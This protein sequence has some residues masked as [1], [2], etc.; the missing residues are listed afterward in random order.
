M[1]VPS[2]CC[3]VHLKF[4]TPSRCVKKCCPYLRRCDKFN[5]PSTLSHCDR[6]YVE[7]L[8]NTHCMHILSGVCKSTNS[9][10]RS[11]YEVRRA[12]K[13]PIIIRRS[14]FWIDQLLLASPNIYWIISIKVAH[15]EE[16]ATPGMDLSHESRFG[17]AWRW[18]RY[19]DQPTPT[20]KSPMTWGVLAN[21]HQ[22]DFHISWINQF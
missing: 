12:D 19:P 3:N 6:D 14:I 11:T 13:E 8:C 15:T 2:V 7:A 21:L 9:E 1:E 17:W 4:V 20:A 22:T 5:S 18:S 16:F 10:K